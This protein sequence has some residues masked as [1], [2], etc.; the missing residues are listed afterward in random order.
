VFATNALFSSRVTRFSPAQP[1]DGRYAI[2]HEGHGGLA[3]EIGADV[4][5]WLLERGWEV[6]AMDMPLLGVNGSDQGTRFPNHHFDLWK[7]D[8]G[9][10]SPVA[11]FMLP[12]KNVVDFIERHA[13]E[14]PTILMMGRSGGGWTTYTYAAL[15]P[16]ITVAVS[17]AGGRPMSQ[18]L[19]SRGGLDVGDYEQSAPEIYSAIRHEDVMIAAGAR[20]SMHVFNV[21]DPC[22]FR[23]LPGDPS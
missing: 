19:D 13:T 7:L 9:V 23:V 11:N 18:R 16:R 14:R 20:G 21:N 5:H 17:V 2:Y 12:V 3:V 1:V 6:Y 15:D 8:D 4:I 10:T 22:C